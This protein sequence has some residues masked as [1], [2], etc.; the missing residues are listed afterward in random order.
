MKLYISPSSGTR[1]IV[2]PIPTAMLGILLKSQF[3][4]ENSSIPSIPPE[5]LRAM[6]PALRRYVK[7]HGH[8]D[9]LTVRTDDHVIF[10]IEV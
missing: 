3:M 5:A 9:F 8:F 7:T 10:R 2:L 4:E 6:I 1:P